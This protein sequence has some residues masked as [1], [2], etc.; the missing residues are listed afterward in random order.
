MSLRSFLQ[1][2]IVTNKDGLTGD[3][4]HLAPEVPEGDPSELTSAGGGTDVAE[5][6]GDDL[7][8]GS[9]AAGGEVGDALPEKRNESAE[10]VAGRTQPMWQIITG[11]EAAEAVSPGGWDASDSGGRSEEGDPAAE[12][13]VSESVEAAVGDDEVDGVD[14]AASQF[15]ETE[16]AAEAW[17]RSGD[18][19]D[20]SGAPEM[21]PGALDGVGD[22]GGEVVE[23][24]VELAEAVVDVEED[25][26]T[27]AVVG[28]EEGTESESGG[29][30]EAGGGELAEAFATS[31]VMGEGDGADL[32][33]EPEGL[34][35]ATEPGHEVVDEEGAGSA[36]DTVDV[37]DGAEVQDVATAVEE[38]AAGD[39][40]GG[41]ADEEPGEPET[42]E[43][44]DVAESRGEA[45][46]ALSATQS[47]ETDGDGAGADEVG[48]SSAELAGVGDDPAGVLADLGGEAEAG[49]E[50]AEPEPAPEAVFDAEPSEG[51]DQDDAEPGEGLGAEDVAANAV[52]SD[53]AGGEAIDASAVGSSVE[54]AGDAPASEESDADGA[55]DAAFGDGVVDEAE[56]EEDVAGQQEMM[57]GESAPAASMDG[58]HGEAGD[59]CAEE[60]EANSEALLGADASADGE[61]GLADDADVVLQTDD[62]AEDAL[63]EAFGPADSDDSETSLQE[64]VEGRDLEAGASVAGD[65]TDGVDSLEVDAGDGDEAFAEVDDGVGDRIEAES[66][67]CA[68]E[69]ASGGGQAVLT[70]DGVEGAVSGRESDPAGAIQAVSDGSLDE[71]TGWWAPEG[72]RVVELPPRLVRPIHEALY[73]ELVGLIDKP[74]VELPELPHVAQ[75]LLPMVGGESYDVKRVASLAG[76]DPALAG[77]LLSVANSVAYGGLKE[78]SRLDLA[79]ARIGQRSLRGLVMAETVKRLA[80]RPDSKQRTVGQELWECSI[81]SGVVMTRLGAWFNVSEDQ[82]FLIGLL[83]DVG[84]LAILRVLHEYQEQTREKAPR[85]VFDQLCD[86][87]H[88]H[89]GMRLAEA[90]NLPDPLPEIIGGHHRIP[91]ENDPLRVQRLLANVADV[92]CALLN[93]S[94]YVPYDFF[95]VASVKALG[96]ADDANTRAILTDLPDLISAQLAGE[97]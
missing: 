48:A 72:E 38:A 23:S 7:P 93:Y 44:V 83:H 90:W 94:S 52:D 60:A 34:S 96:L 58:A 73:R 71:E 65:G 3:D 97:A 16:G 86:Q 17:M 63:A 18:G 6:A 68:A 61:V 32:G 9:E 66:D 50:D 78:V 31:D 80:I 10:S 62:S 59:S 24:A 56:S 85:V 91:G 35:G 84:K 49:G 89:I 51:V 87:W 25:E 13:G 26:A 95:E 79:I 4:E 33:E 47:V 28:G 54:D 77:R 1:K 37:A 22:V 30:F 92:V 43:H 14:A 11:A 46:E 12:A 70:T 55:V 39:A 15:M 81:A 29:A 8:V 27:S 76:K 88:E 82:A 53:V 21:D 41:E 36:V 2:M 64:E 75:Q 74:D 69:D 67:L 20:R 19:D 5:V 57:E 40:G 45:P 42:V